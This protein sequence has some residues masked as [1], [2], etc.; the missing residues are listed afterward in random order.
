MAKIN[1]SVASCAFN[2][3]DKKEC[4][5]KAIQV[6]PCSNCNNGVPEDETCCRSYEESRY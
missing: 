3:R 6:N 1:C 2:A 4:T 5:L